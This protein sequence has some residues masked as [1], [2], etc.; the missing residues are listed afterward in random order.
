[1][2]ILLLTSERLKHCVVA[3]T[4]RIIVVQ[5]H[6]TL[7]SYRNDAVSKTLVVHGI[8]DIVRFTFDRYLM[9]RRRLWFENKKN[10]TV[11]YLCSGVS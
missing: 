6:Q 11:G 5:D 10:T 1:M 3:H 4:I 9:T 8:K 2:L 7:Q